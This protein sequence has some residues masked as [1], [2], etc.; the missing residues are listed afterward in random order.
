MQ[1]QHHLHTS[2]QIDKIHQ[3]KDGEIYRATVKEHTGK[4]EA[5][6]SIRGRE[7]HVRFDGEVPKGDR[8]S[9]QIIDSN[10]DVIVVKAIE[11]GRSSVSSS[12]LE[13]E[14]VNQTLRQ[15]GGQQ[16]SKELR[17]AASMLVE[18]GIPLTKDAVQ[19][20]QRFLSEGRVESRLQ[21]IQAI[22]N[23]RLDVT[24]TILN[25][26]HEAM[27]GR[28]L[29]EVLNDLAKDIN[30]EFKVQP[31]VRERLEQPSNQKQLNLEGRA[32]QQLAAI[33][34]VRQEVQA[35]VT[36]N[37]ARERIETRLLDSH[38]LT[39]EQK[40]EIGRTLRADQM[41]AVRGNE[42]AGVERI[43]Q[44]LVRQDGG[45]QIENL[46]DSRREQPQM[47]TRD[48][49][50]IN[51]EQGELRQQP[52]T[53]ALQQSMVIRVRQAVQ[54]SATVNQAMD[55]IKARLLDTNLLSREQRLEIDRAMR[56]AETDTTRGNERV[57]VNRIVQT[58]ERIERGMQLENHART[59]KTKDEQI[60]VRLNQNEKVQEQT[61]QV[62]ELVQSESSTSRA[63]DRVQQLVNQISS[64]SSRP[65]ERLINESRLLEQVAKERMLQALNR[66]ERI[67]S[68]Q[69]EQ[70]VVKEAKRVI[71]RERL[72]QAIRDQIN[73]MLSERGVLQNNTVEE[74]NKAL[75]QSE[76]L[77]E[78]AR[79]RLLQAMEQPSTKTVTKGEV[80]PLNEAVKESKAILQKEASFEKII[81]KI[82]MLF[83][84]QTGLNGD[85]ELEINQ[86][87]EA[88][89]EFQQQGREIK[90]RQEMAAVIDEIEQ[91]VKPAEPQRFQSEARAYVDN[92]MF[93]TSINMNSK[94][95]AVTVVT[96]KLAQMTADFKQ[97]QRDISKTLDQVSRQI[98]QFRNLAQPVA[99]P[100]L[101]TTIK[102]LDQAIL[103]SDMMLLADMKTERQ[104]MQA[105][106]QL[107]EAKKLLARGKHGEANRIVHEVK[108]L[109]DKVNFQPSDTKVK[110]YTAASE[111]ALKERQ[112]PS[113]SFTNQFSEAARGPLQA[114]SPRAMFEMVRAVGLN[115]D[116]ELAQVLVSNR[117]RELQESAERN[118]KSTLM[119]LARS[120]EEGTR[121]Q[122]LATQALAN[123]TGQQLLSRSD[124]Q[125]N[126]QS[127]VLQFPFLLEDKVENL[128]V[129]VNSRNEG[130]QV[131][132]QNCS[133]YF[134]IETP[135]MGEIGIAVSAA[136]KQ[137]SVTI[138]NDNPDF[139]AKMAPLVQITIEKL[140]EIGYSING[141]KYARLSTEET[142]INSEQ[143][144]QKTRQQPVFTEK[145]FD[146][147]V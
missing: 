122:Q 90:A 1:I 17:Q 73:T 10:N 82:Q 57:G 7:V 49:I 124:Q 22:I 44:T 145:G 131:D 62:R 126:L 34:E 3:V 118:I 94:S 50:A 111:K 142:Q 115:R 72:T 43:V 30:R 132:W 80:P 146:F 51:R 67:S 86:R 54:A 107:A 32:Q 15:L 65:T 114:G 60:Q 40:E 12:R 84:G 38:H 11:E 2:G 98:D 24:P 144:E 37:Q 136:E 127:M 59:V 33:R 139:Q 135:K 92:E 9:I 4:E 130:Q 45:G 36:V 95:I 83:N 138:K 143:Q 125:S 26:V 66:S 89:K 21:T 77:Q 41:D 69:S 16:P 123:V 128:Q 23:K 147:K 18:K 133:L 28:P 31:A 63:A 106:S 68:V 113:Q 61:R 76:Q 8:V 47:P 99:K 74:V 100:L 108:Q 137:L 35:S 78:V 13:R 29:N 140:S 79:G 85:M 91:R 14:T 87:L 19:D 75:K 110:H 56:T 141:I 55:Q 109:I 52:E 58:L 48:Q 105:S 46:V 101:E 112:L 121:V 104:L 119:Q 25:S 81:Q 70:D 129:F 102:K 88:A 5:V 53:Q 71:Q 6:L 20:L 103:K 117:E 96:E 93:Q 116:S 120:E 97:L 27:H 64:D 42:R 39:R 134:L